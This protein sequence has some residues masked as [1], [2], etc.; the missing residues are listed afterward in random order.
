[1]EL[2]NQITSRQTPFN[3]AAGLGGEGA[4]SN[5]DATE[6]DLIF[7]RFYSEQL[8]SSIRSGQ[9]AWAPDQLEK[10]NPTSLSEFAA[11]FNSDNVDVALSPDELSDKFSAWLSSVGLASDGFRFSAPAILDVVDE[12]GL[13]HSQLANPALALVTELELNAELSQPGLVDLSQAA[14]L[15]NHSLEQVNLDQ[16]ADPALA[17]A[18]ELELN[19]ELSQP[20]L[21]D[22]SQ[23][24]GQ[25]NHSL[26]QV[27][28]DQLADPALA[29]VTELSPNAELAKLSL[30][31]TVE[32][33]TL[34]HQNDVLA[35]N[36]ETA[37]DSVPVNLL[38]SPLLQ[39]VNN[40]TVIQPIVTPSIESTASI[41]DVQ[42]ENAEESALLNLAGLTPDI[43]QVQSSIQAGLAASAIGANVSVL[44]SPATLSPSGM[45]FSKAATVNLSAASS[46]AGLPLQNT[47]AMADGFIAQA[48]Q[49][50][51][52]R[53]G[54]SAQT[55]NLASTAQTLLQHSVIQQHTAQ[56][57]TARALE[58]GENTRAQTT[59]ATLL[60]DTSVKGAKTTAPS[61]ASI[62]YPLNHQKWNEALG[63]RM[64]FMANQS[65]QLAQIS[66]NP[67]KLGP[68]QLRLQLDRDQ[69]MTVSMSANHAT[70]R[71]ALEAAIPRLKEML[72]EAGVI[73]DQIDV[74]EESVFDQPK[75]RNTGSASTHQAGD[76]LVEQ[77]LMTTQLDSDNLID[78]YA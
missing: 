42:A 69:M 4:W 46:V 71:E 60:T 75:E 33:D 1:M 5:Q 65:I 14:G 37:N 15:A 61:L 55:L 2:L 17:L 23:A 44:K 67:E 10:L 29:L 11:F 73:F 52:I 7:A 74:Q 49:S 66:L 50:E 53:G 45:A 21:V 68:I 39:E 72:T 70:T 19:A 78:F 31:Q 26:E 20:G 62:S 40:G 36:L 8:A 48:L 54:V 41:N 34:M 47:I 12:E 35:L 76:D 24:A 18:T 25:A 16:L 56:A 30:S 13:I 28:L 63:K 57:Q 6:A 27:N 3:P 58:E 22:L 43:G 51:A 38:V 9:Q 64:I 77:D 32:A 59:E